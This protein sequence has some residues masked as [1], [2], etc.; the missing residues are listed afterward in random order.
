VDKMTKDEFINV[1]VKKRKVTKTILLNIATWLIAIIVYS[2]T[3][4]LFFNLETI[5]VIT[6]ASGWLVGELITVLFFYIFFYQ[7]E[8]TKMNESI[9]KDIIE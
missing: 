1:F 4:L 8:T 9:I 3:S 5:M 7:S 6:F 2:L